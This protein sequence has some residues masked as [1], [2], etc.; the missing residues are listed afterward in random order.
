MTKQ[1]FIKKLIKLADRL[2]IK[3]DIDSVEI[4][5][6]IIKDLGETQPMQIEVEI[7]EDEEEEIRK[8]LEESLK[9]FTN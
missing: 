9:A 3:D 1:E 5:D 8:I 2:D 6:D 4:V 7:P